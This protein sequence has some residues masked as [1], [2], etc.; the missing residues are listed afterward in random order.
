MRFLLKGPRSLIRTI[1]AV[2]LSTFVTRTVVPKGSVRCAAVRSNMLYL[3]PLAVS[4]PW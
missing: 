3:S 1:T 2:R 4:R